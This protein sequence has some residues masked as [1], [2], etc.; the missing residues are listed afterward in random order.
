MS[1]YE[2]EYC[3]ALVR[4]DENHWCDALAE[5]TRKFFPELFNNTSTGCPLCQDKNK[6]IAELEARLS[7]HD[8]SGCSVSL[9]GNEPVA[10]GLRRER[11]ASEAKWLARVTQ[12]E[13]DNANLERQCK[14][15]RE[16]ITELTAERHRDALDGQAALDEANAKIK[17]LEHERDDAYAIRTAANTQLREAE[18]AWRLERDSLKA[19]VAALK[20]VVE[21][22]REVVRGIRRC[23]ARG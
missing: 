22:S 15:D 10:D 2:C 18:Q 3:H 14:R 17:A 5:R 7:A 19:E 1:M 4:D 20:V 23:T 21:A 16:R 8:A 6:R 13:Q 11:H 9:S 12:L